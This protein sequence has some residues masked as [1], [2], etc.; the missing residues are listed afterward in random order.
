VETDRR[1]VEE[2]VARYSRMEPLQAYYD[3]FSLQKG[4]RGPVGCDSTPV[5]Q[6]CMRSASRVLDL[7]CGNGWR[8][9]E[10]HGLFESG[11]GIDVSDF[12]LAIARREAAKAGAANLEF[13]QAKAKALPLPDGSFDF[14]YTERGPLGRSDPSL[15][16]AR[17]VLRPGGRIF[18]ETLGSLNLME[19]RQVFQDYNVSGETLLATLEQ[20]RERF[21]RLGFSLSLLSSIRRDL[22]FTDLY[23]WLAWQCSIWRYLGDPLPW[24]RDMG[25]VDEFARRHVAADGSVTITL[26]LIWIGGVKTG[27]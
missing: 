13:I 26:Q 1:R 7:G 18:A 3:Q 25:L 15:I 12:A 10:C 11:V 16:E 19:P 6:D 5:I 14:L 22:A 9:I 17:R 20:E 21:E 23:Q 2:I 24:I 8:L 4:A 27:G